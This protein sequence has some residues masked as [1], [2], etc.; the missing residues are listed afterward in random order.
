MKTKS[1]LILLCFICF[2]NEAFSQENKPLKEVLNAIETRYN[3]KL[4]YSENLVKDKMVHLS[5]LEFSR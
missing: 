2:L 4:S 5:F 3:V 1:L